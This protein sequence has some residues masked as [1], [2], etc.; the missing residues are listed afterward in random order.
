MKE[1]YFSEKNRKEYEENTYY[2]LTGDTYGK[3]QS[4]ESKDYP[5]NSLSYF[6]FLTSRQIWTFTYA[7]NWISQINFYHHYVNDRVMYIT[8]STVLVNLLKFQNYYCIVKKCL[9]TIR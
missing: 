5:N 6:D 8:G 7:M 4:I 9:I 3:L 2:F 1:K